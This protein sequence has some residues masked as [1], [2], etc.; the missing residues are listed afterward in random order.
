MS[1]AVQT[2]TQ[3]PKKAFNFLTNQWAAAAVIVLVAA[4]L[5]VRVEAKEPGKVRATLAKL[6]ILGR[7]AAGG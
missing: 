6:P 3:A 4:I 7:W 5:F 1:D 2:V